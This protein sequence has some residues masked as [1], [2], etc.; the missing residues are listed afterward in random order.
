MTTPKGSDRFYMDI[1]YQ[2]VWET[3][4]L[5][6]GKTS[7]QD[8]YNALVKQNRFNPWL[9]RIKHGNQNESRTASDL[10]P[11][12][13]DTYLHEKKRIMPLVEEMDVDPSDYKILSKSEKEKARD[14]NEIRKKVI[15][16]ILKK[17]SLIPDE[18]DQFSPE[19]LVDEIIKEKGLDDF[20][21]KH[22][23]D[24]SKDKIFKRKHSDTIANAIIESMQHEDPKKSE[25]K[26]TRDRRKQPKSRRRRTTRTPRTVARKPQSTGRSR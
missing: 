10:M 11:K 21:E 17:H 4:N 24:L 7:I 19:Q 26:S 1:T 12:E 20:I 13:V 18:F 16:K 25:K 3:F 9:Y 14:H 6:E 5:P 22:F 23:S 8:V 2:D 15:H